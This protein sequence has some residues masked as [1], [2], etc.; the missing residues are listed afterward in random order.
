M[1]EIKSNII[2]PND[3]SD[4]PLYI[5]LYNHYKELISSG[6][7]KAENKLPS[8]R[9]CAKERMISRTTVEAAYLQLVAEGYVTS[10]PGSG[11]YVSELNYKDIHRVEPVQHSK[12]R[13]E[14]KPL[15]DFAT[16]AVDYKS[17]DFDLLFIFRCL[18]LCCNKIR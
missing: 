9:R 1:N 17:F 10:R 8:I 2:N 18:N 5:Q 6:R 4:T 16:Y 3:S 14:N 7:L 13:E 11:F 12:S 15:Y